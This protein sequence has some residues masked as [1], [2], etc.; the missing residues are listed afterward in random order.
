MNQIN[1]SLHNVL[2]DDY[3]MNLDFDDDKISV[4]MF[5]F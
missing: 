1:Y 3:E 5:Y 2:K 4:K